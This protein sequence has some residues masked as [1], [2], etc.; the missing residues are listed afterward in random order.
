VALG[1]AS[2]FLWKQLGHKALPP[3]EMR[4]SLFDK[5]AIAVLPFANLSQDPQQEY[6]TDG[7]TNDII[8][9]LSKF[10]NLI[11]IASSTAFTYKGQSVK[12]TQIGKE[13]SVPYVV[14]GSVQAAGDRVR[15]N[16]Q[17]TD[18][19]TGEQL[20]AQR[21]DEN[22]K[23]LFAIQDEITQAIVGTMA[24]KIEATERARVMRKDTSNYQ[25]YDYYIRGTGYLMHSTQSMNKKARQLL[26]KAIELDPQFASA[27]TA[28]GWCYHNLVEFGWTEFVEQASKRAESL[29][30]KALSIDN[31]QASAPKTKTYL[32]NLFKLLLFI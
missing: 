4:S 22:K 29:A 30:R 26:E 15:I 20:W 12:V 31:F 9:D 7:I 16:A 25:A 18:A 3:K 6:F 32:S 23:E 17:L 19:A 27:Y 28:L 2:I 14:Q 11:V 8:T 1:G 5:P 24:I 21:F 10:S 13:L